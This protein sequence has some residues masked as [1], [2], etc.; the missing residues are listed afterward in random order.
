ME[1]GILVLCGACFVE[2]VY[3]PLFPFVFCLL[4]QGYKLEAERD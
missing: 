2:Y 3:V 1:V 4:F